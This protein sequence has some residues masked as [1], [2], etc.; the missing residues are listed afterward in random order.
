MER[1]LRGIGR[2]RFL[3]LRQHD[4]RRHRGCPARCNPRVSGYLE[5]HHS[6]ILTEFRAIVAA[7]W[8]GGACSRSIRS[9][10]RWPVVSG[11]LPRRR[12]GSCQP[13]GRGATKNRGSTPR[14]SSGQTRWAPQ[15]QENQNQPASPGGGG[16]PSASPGREK[17][18]NVR[19]E[20]Q[21]R[22]K[23]RPRR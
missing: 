12:S 5:R 10:L 17:R 23:K 21:Q 7:T 19:I 20:Y 1:R 8:C 9:R 15:L 22:V 4:Q 3:G 18:I 14:T 11:A 6:E 2:A 13:R 16:P